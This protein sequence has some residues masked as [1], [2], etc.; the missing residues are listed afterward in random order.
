MNVLLLALKDELV[1][2]ALREKIQSLQPDLHIVITDQRDQMEPLLAEIEI[3][4][5]HFPIQFISRAPNLR[6]FQQW[7]AGTDWLM[8]HPDVAA[9]DLILTNASGVHAIPISEHILALLLAFARRLPESIRAQEQHHWLGWEDRS[10]AFELYGKNL[11]LVGVGAIGRRTAEVATALGMHV[12]GVRSDP[13]KSAPGVE[14]MIGPEALE[15]ALPGADFAV[16]TLPLTAETRGMFGAKAF[17]GMKS[18]AYLI[19][20][21]RG[22]TVNEADLVQA[23]QN[24]Q[25]AGAGL[26]VFATEPLPAESALWALPNVIITSHYSGDTPHYDERALAIFMDNLERYSHGLPMR[27]VVDKQRG[28]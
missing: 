12:T 17:A 10:G 7:G 16:L 20:I 8:K 21:G 19:N 22:G 9:S 26:D 23:L 2:A 28:Y 13:G 4:A 5:G 3:A 14:H 1:S 24:G 15:T 27:N 25:I 6:W 11:L 18:S